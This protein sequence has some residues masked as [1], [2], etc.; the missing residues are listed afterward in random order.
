[1]SSSIWASVASPAGTMIQTAR[2]FSSFETS[3]AI[4]NARDRALALDLLRLLR[5]PVV[6]DDLVAV[7]HQAAD[8]VRA[9]PTETDEPDPHPMALPVDGGRVARGRSVS[10]VER[11]A[12]GRSRAAVRARSPRWTR[13]I[14]R[15]CDSIAAKSP[16]AWASIS[17][18][19]VYG[20]PGIGRSTG[21]SAVSCRNQP[22]GG[23]PLW[24]WPVEWRNRGP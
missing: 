1:M 16:S 13:R 22:L 24:S 17:R 4:E 23:P 7:P 12:Q 20:Q 14:G 5:R 19:K 6:G 18:P 21:W 2:G 10:R 9:H 11:L 8:H 3:S 15:S